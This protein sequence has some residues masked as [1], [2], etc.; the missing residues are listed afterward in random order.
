MEN[1]HFKLIETSEGQW[2]ETRHD[3]NG[4]YYLESSFFIDGKLIKHK[5]VYESKEVRDNIFDS[6]D[7]EFT[8]GIIKFKKDLDKSK[9]FEIEVI[10]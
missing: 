6:I 2:L 8:T 3:K 1:K 4:K 7:V 10:G 9:G 5:D